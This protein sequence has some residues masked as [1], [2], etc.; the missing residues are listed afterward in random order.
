MTQLRLMTE[1]R[2]SIIADCFPEFVQRFF[3]TMFP[4]R[5]YPLWAVDALNSVNIRLQSEDVKQCY[6]TESPVGN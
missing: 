1:M 4:S 3:D 2:D 5:N 6:V